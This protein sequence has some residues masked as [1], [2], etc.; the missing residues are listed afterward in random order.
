MCSTVLVRGSQRRWW[1]YYELFSCGLYEIRRAWMTCYTT[2]KKFYENE[3]LK[4]SVLFCRHPFQCT[5]WIPAYNLNFSV[6]L[7]FQSTIW[8]FWV[9]NI[10]KMVRISSTDQYLKCILFFFNF[11][12]QFIQHMLRVNKFTPS[13]RTTKFYVL[14]VNNQF[15]LFFGIRLQTAVGCC[16]E[17]RSST[18]LHL[19][20]IMIRIRFTFPLISLHTWSDY[21]SISSTTKKRRMY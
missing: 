2:E 13:L 14:C 18:R 10:S 4:C 17:S 11:H 9:K 15:F 16:C 21:W 3:S 20:W 7:E 8:N 19:A 12:F 6:Q 5:T 1:Q